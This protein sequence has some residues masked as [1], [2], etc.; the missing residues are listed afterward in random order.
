MSGGWLRTGS[1]WGNLG[2]MQGRDP[3]ADNT[4]ESLLSAACGRS[5]CR[6]LRPLSGS[7]TGSSPRH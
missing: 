7:D 4:A 6:E 1:I 2:R 3:E 5:G